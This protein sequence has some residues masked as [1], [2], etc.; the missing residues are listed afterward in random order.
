M[1]WR[2]PIHR[3]IPRRHPGAA[4]LL[5]LASLA[6]LAFVVT[7]IIAAATTR[8]IWEAQ[9]T[10]RH[11]LRRE[12]F[13]ALEATLGVL[14][15]FAQIDGALFGPAQG[16]EN[17]LEVARFEPGG[18]IKIDVELRDESGLYGLQALAENTVVARRFFQDLGID[19]TQ[20]QTLA[21][22]LADWTDAD[23]AVRAN[24]AERD[25]YGDGIAPPNRPVQ[26]LDELRLIHGFAETFFTENGTGNALWE[27]F[28]KS[29]SLLGTSA[30]PNINTAPEPVLEVLA[31]R[32]SFDPQTVIAARNG[33]NNISGATTVFRNAGDLGR[34]SLPPALGS[35][36]SFTCSQ[37]RVIVRASKGDA[38]VVV[39]SLLNNANGRVG[40][41]NQ[42]VNALLSE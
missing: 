3:P 30:T 27:R 1:T 14:G 5:V 16:W 17:P 39:D 18:G 9:R 24:G 41:R 32:H 4:L 28:S 40:V 11:T 31:S 26:T 12:A 38:S 22:C 6:L 21:D 15:A 33:S 2:T 25:R 7:E 20:A 29:V 42:R 35:V 34:A 8:L 23:E 13:S 36:V 10:Q 19:E 37:L